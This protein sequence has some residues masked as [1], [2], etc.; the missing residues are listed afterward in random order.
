[1]PPRI[2]AILKRMFYDPSH[3]AGFGTAKNLL[4]AAR[5][6]RK[7]ISL[8]DVERWLESQD[9]FTLHRKI[10]RKFPR[11]MFVSKGLHRMWQSDLVDMQAIKKENRG[12]RFIL[13]VIDV[14]SRQAFAVPMKTKKPQDVVKAFT[15]VLKMA[16]PAKPAFL[17]TDRGM[18]YLGKPF[19]KWLAAKT[20][21]H[22]FTQNQETK[23]AIVERWNRTLKTRMF[24]YFTANNTLH[25]LAALPQLVHSYNNRTHRILGM[26]PAAV[27]SKNEKKLWDR[28]YK[29]YFEARKKRYKYRIN[30]AV[31]ITKAR[32]QFQKGYVRG[33]KE[34]K[35]R[36]VDRYATIPPTY[37]L[38]DSGNEILEGSFYEKELGKVSP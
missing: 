33:W 6:Q 14:F 35:F 21:K 1:M 36:I 19:Q 30:D 17:H 7:N 11:R 32:A 9:A 27:N 31:R 22:Y 13:T 24:K 20:I 28:Q 10:I 12:M 18:E 3:P 16:A 5:L 29:A 8:N 4:K 38:I 15:Q 34:E 37:R 25:Y 2:N 26:A 23:A